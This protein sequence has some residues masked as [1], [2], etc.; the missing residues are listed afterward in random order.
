MRDKITELELSLAHIRWQQW[1]CSLETAEPTVTLSLELN[2]APKYD[3]L[4]DP[5]NLS[6]DELNKSFQCDKLNDA[7]RDPQRP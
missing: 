5:S 3:I 4:D 6:H 7:S 1:I 2:D